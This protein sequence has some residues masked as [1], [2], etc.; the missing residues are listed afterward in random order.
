MSQENVD[1]I[2]ANLV[3]YN[4][5]DV[6]AMLRLWH[7]E[8]EWFSA[9][10]GNV[11]A[12]VYRGHPAVREYF[13]DIAETWDENTISDCDYSDLGERVLVCGQIHMLGHASGITVDQPIFLLYELR[14]RTIYRG[15]S[16]LDRTEAFAAAGLSEG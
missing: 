13:D 5:R 8:G 12:H 9:G 2:R 3:A 16:Y 7:P 11:E 15:H 14:D 10:A 1:V 6:E 4:A